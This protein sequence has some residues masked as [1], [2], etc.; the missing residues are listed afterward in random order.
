MDLLTFAEWCEATTLGTAIRESTWAFAVIE[1]VH[2][3]ALS[4]IGGAILLVDLRLLGLGLTRHTVRDLARD[5][6]RWQTWSLLVLIITGI[7]LFLSESVKCYYSFPFWYKISALFVI[8]IFTYTIR[9]KIVFAPEGQFGRGAAAAVA[10][11]S[12]TMWFTVGAAGR[13]IGFSG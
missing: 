1:S 8:I 2:L 13:W 10:I 7:G 5:A 3:L 9:K 6:Q 12:M 11:V 4:V